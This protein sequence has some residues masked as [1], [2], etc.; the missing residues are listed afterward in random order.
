MRTNNESLVF[1]PTAGKSNMQELFW[2]NVSKVGQGKNM[3]QQYKIRAGEA[4]L[5]N[6]TMFQ[7]IVGKEIQLTLRANEITFLNKQIRPLFSGKV[8]QVTNGYITLDPVAVSLS[9]LNQYT[10][11]TPLHFPI[12]RISNFITEEH[13]NEK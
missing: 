3:F 10:F 4:I 1:K 13:G 9:E 5:A 8:V 6:N 12:D 7:H 2:S 11:Q